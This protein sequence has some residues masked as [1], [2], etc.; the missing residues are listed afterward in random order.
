MFFVPD[1]LVLLPLVS[2]MYPGKNILEL[3]PNEKSG[4]GIG[5]Y[6]V[7]LVKLS[8]YKRILF[9]FLHYNVG[10]ILCGA[11]LIL[12][13]TL[14]YALKLLHCWP[15]LFLKVRALTSIPMK[16]S[17]CNCFHHAYNIYWLPLSQV[18]AGSTITR[19]QQGQITESTQKR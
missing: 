3:I 13:L 9:C 19:G 1:M 18:H 11:L 14:V 10:A 7:F 2:R 17:S 8:L 6:F 16:T 5:Y 4:D 12:S 15:F